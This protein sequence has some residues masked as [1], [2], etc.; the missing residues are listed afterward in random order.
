MSEFFEKE[1]SEVARIGK[2]DLKEILNTCNTIIQTTKTKGT[3]DS[4][5]YHQLCGLLEMLEGVGFAPEN[6]LEWRYKAA[7]LLRKVTNKK[8]WRHFVQS[9][10]QVVVLQR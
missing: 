6:T 3:E 4:V 8:Q 10:K 9:L 5:I 2:R 1:G 7:E